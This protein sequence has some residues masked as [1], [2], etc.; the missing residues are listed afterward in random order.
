MEI[1]MLLQVTLTDEQLQKIAWNCCQYQ[2]LPDE[3]ACK[4]W[5]ED[6]LQTVFADLPMLPDPIREESK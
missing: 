5:L 4:M 1:K 2:F 6:Q 3:D